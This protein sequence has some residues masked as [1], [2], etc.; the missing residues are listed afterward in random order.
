VVVDDRVKGK[1]LRQGGRLADVAPTALALMG[2]EK[3]K[4][5]TGETLV[6]G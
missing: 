2:L 1:T 5:M 6:Q 4:E 3:P